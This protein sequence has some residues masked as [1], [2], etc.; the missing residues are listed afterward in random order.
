MAVSVWLRMVRF[1]AIVAAAAALPVGC[2]FPDCSKERSAVY[3]A[4]SPGWELTEYCLDDECL[5]P[6]TLRY[7]GGYD[8]P[9]AIDVGTRV[10]S[11]K[12]RIGIIATDGTQRVYEGEIETLRILGDG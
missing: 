11:Y 6:D 8:N 2:G 1:A 12:Y 10:H 5:S 3:V 4:L 9:Y 7:G